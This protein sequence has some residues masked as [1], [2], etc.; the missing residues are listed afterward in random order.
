ML[1]TINYGFELVYFFIFFNEIEIV[2]WKCLHGFNFITMS[3]CNKGHRIIVK[4]IHK[5]KGVCQVSLC[6]G[7]EICLNGLAIV[8]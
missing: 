2:E 4:N 3:I 8:K 7:I 6:L 1:P 5:Y